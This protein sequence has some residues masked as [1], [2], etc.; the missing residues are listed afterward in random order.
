MAIF[1]AD[2]RFAALA[3]QGVHA[4]DTGGRVRMAYD[5]F[6]I[7]AGN[8]LDPVPV[9]DAVR[10]GGEGIPKGARVLQGFLRHDDL[11]TGAALVSFRLLNASGSGDI[12]LTGGGTTF[13]GVSSVLGRILSVTDVARD[14]PPVVTRSRVFPVM[15]V[16]AGANLDIAGDCALT[17]FYVLD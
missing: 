9:G 4:I 3:G 12:W 10:F 2:K 1:L 6:T 15:T 5:E 14:N 8:V 17:V 7:G 13:I 11:S 16:L